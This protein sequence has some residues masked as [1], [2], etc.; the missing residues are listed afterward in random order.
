MNEYTLR[1]ASSSDTAELA[2]LINLAYRVEDF[3][4]TGD[5]TDEA[6][7][8]ESMQTGPFFLLADHYERI[9]SCIHI[10]VRGDRG[11]FGMLSVH[12]EGQRHGLGRR[13]IAEAEDH[14]RLAGCEWMDLEVV[15][16]RDELP[17]FYKSL[18]YRVTG[19]A[20]FPA[21]ERTKLPCHFMVM[22]KPLVAES[23]VAKEVAR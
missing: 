18:G 4:K 23:G 22:S 21:M 3:F 14:C 16:L 7:V 8:A 20:P 10:E 5:R 11:Y 19:T 2:A 9:T 17:P 13:L 1:Q 6:D 15:N 12:P